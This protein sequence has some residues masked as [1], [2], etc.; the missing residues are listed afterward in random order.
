MLIER[1][2]AAT[3]RTMGLAREVGAMRVPCVGC[4]GCRGLCEALIEVM[5][6]PD[7]ILHRA[8]RNAP[9]EGQV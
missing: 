5:V 9:R 7:V 8:S 2:K 6:L 4:S 3:E 1:N